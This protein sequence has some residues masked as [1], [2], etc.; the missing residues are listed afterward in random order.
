MEKWKL[1][2]LRSAESDSEEQRVTR[3]IGWDTKML[4]QFQTQPQTQ[5]QAVW[6][7]WSL[8][9]LLVKR[10][11]EDKVFCLR[12]SLVGTAKHE[13]P[14]MY[15]HHTLKYAKNSPVWLQTVAEGQAAVS[16]SSTPKSVS[17]PE[18]QCYHPAWNYC[19]VGTCP[20]IPMQSL[21][22]PHWNFLNTHIPKYSLRFA[23][24]QVLYFCCRIT[25]NHGSLSG[26]FRT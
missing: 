6:F 7:A 4:V 26:T 16:D 15:D 11:K 21:G 18:H 2:C 17:S 8:N 24:T 13:V 20:A 3:T 10:T 25:L 1:R 5:Q 14:W 9:K 19:Q 22:S 23:K 12:E